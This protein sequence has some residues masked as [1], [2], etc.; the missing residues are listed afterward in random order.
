MIKSNARSQV[1]TR[2][3]TTAGLLSALSVVLSMTPLG[4]IPLGIASATT[5]HIPAII[6]AVLEG[7]Y[8]GAAIGLI[9]GLTSFLRSTTPLFADPRVAIIPRLLIGIIAYFVYRWTKSTPLAAVAGTLT[10]TVGVLTTAVMLKYLTPQ[11]AWGIAL[12]NGIF[13]IIVAV[14]LTTAI[15]KA[16]NRARANG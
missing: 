16:V 9:F 11:V 2:Q 1:K 8:V 7:P 3:L 12:K 4:Y 10:N 14:L 5:M 13:E 6:G 15:V